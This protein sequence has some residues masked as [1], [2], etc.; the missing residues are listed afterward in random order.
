MKNQGGILRHFVAL[1]MTSVL[2]SGGE[3]VI[4]QPDEEKLTA[5]SMRQDGVPQGEIIGPIVLNSKV[6]PGTV[7]N[8]WVYVPA[9]YDSGK[10]ACLC[11]VKDGL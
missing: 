2:F 5:D 8:Y 9:Q 6:F 10:A 3:S 4:A 7:R 1:V 11:V